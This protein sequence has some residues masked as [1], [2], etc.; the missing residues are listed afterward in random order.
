MKALLLENIHPEGVRVLRERGFEVES[1][2][3]ALGEA[4]LI[5]ALA[6]VDLLGIRSTTNVSADVIRSAPRLRAIGAGR[7]NTTCPG[8]RPFGGR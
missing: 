3:G 5:Q 2:P 6:G 1:R 8:P 7:V 4:D